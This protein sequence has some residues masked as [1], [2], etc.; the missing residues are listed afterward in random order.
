MSENIYDQLKQIMHKKAEQISKNE[1]NDIIQNVETNNR[2]EIELRRKFTNIINDRQ[3]LFT[4]TEK[5]LQ[6]RLELYQTVISLIYLTHYFNDV[7]NQL[8]NAIA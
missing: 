3:K 5:L 1:I 6:T 8:N 4:E 7:E 2:D